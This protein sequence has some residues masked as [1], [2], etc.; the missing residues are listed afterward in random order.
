MVQSGILMTALHIEMLTSTCIL[1]REGQLQ[2]PSF[3]W[4]V[5]ENLEKLNRSSEASVRLG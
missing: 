4:K 1:F 5:Q 2:S 3:K